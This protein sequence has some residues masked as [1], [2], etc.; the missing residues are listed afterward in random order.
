MVSITV[1]PEYGYV[2]FGAGILPYFTSFYLGGKVMKMRKSCDVPYP[3]CYGV[4][5]FHKK[6]DEFNRVQRGHQNYLE[7]VH[8]YQ[9]MTLIGGLKHPIACA[10]G[11]VLF[12]IGSNLYMTG[13]ADLTL[14]VKTAR[15][16][17]GGAI[18]W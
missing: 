9:L 1:P 7:N 2:V 14:D 10:V 5:G 12:C 4:P 11:T 18:K 3:N 17:K 15:Y 8:D 6:A 13:Y 16:K